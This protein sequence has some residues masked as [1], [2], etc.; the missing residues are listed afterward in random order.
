MREITLT[1]LLRIVPHLH[2]MRLHDADAFIFRK[3]GVRNAPKSCIA[4]FCFLDR[5]QLG[6]PR[7][8]GVMRMR[9]VAVVGFFM[10]CR[11]GGNKMHFIFTDKL[12]KHHAHLK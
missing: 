12:G 8:V 1:L 3:E 9:D 6:I 2:Q 4:Q 7:D 11:S 10:V 5:G